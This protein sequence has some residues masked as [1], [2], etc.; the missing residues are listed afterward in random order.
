MMVAKFIFFSL[1]ARNYFIARYI[2][3]KP[4]FHIFSQK[5][6]IKSAL[7][8]CEKIISQQT[9]L[10]GTEDVE[11][12]SAHKISSAHLQRKALMPLF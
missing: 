4:A 3:C 5:R 11:R 7:K 2:K 9:A 1:L 12:D 8:I 6:T 10:G